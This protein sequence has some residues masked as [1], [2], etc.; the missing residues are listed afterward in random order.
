MRNLVYLCQRA[1]RMDCVFIDND[2]C[3]YCDVDIHLG[4]DFV[5]H[6]LPRRSKRAAR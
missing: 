3:S 1:H 2:I 5:G 6:L 4:D